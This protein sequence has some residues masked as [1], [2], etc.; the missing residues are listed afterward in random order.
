[1]KG[2]RIY[3][4][5]LGLLI[6]SFFILH[7]SPSYA[8]PMNISCPGA[9]EVD[10]V[11]TLFFFADEIHVQSKIGAVDWYATAT[12]TPVQTGSEDFY[13]DDGGYYIVKNGV[14]YSPFYVFRCQTS[15]L[16]MTVEANCDNTILRF[17]GDVNPYTYIRRNGTRGTYK[18][19]CSVEYT[20]LAWN[21]T[22]WADSAVLTTVTLSEAVRLPAMYTATPIQLCYDT[23][24]RETLGLAPACVA[25]ELVEDDVTAV[26]MQLTSLAVARGKEGEK[27]NELNR[28]TRQDII[29]AT[30]SEDYSGALEV[31]FYTNPTPAVLFYRWTIYK[32]SEVIATRN[33][34]D[35]RYLFSEP[36][37]YRVV[38]AV[39]NQQCVTDSMSMIVNISES[40]LAVP[41]FFTPGGSC[42]NA[43]FRVAYRSLREFHCW[44]YN[45]W[46]KLVF[47]WTDPAKGWDGTIN[48]RLA[49]DGAYYYVVRALGTDAPK[50]AGYIG[51]KATYQKKKQSGDQSVIGVYQLS[52]DINLIRCRK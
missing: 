43:E 31:A 7:F 5:W 13:P 38:C 25:G 24:I 16:Q 44:V 23:D 8:L 14:E 10:G 45:R 42:P 17:T 36:G 18:R 40:Y 46:G 35:I 37:S 52:G 30:T 20:A 41:N 21:G 32:A 49:A 11:D 28:P 2:K 34:K 15:A 6:L 48:G 3:N 33:D 12:G 39:S 22:E 51:I 50:N 19:N 29:T 26:A 47:E 4:E 27:S 1:M 9:H